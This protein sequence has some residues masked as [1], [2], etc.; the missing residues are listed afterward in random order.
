M[1]NIPISG[2]GIMNTVVKRSVVVSL[3]MAVLSQVAI[4]D[5]ND[6]PLNDYN[7]RPGVD[8]GWAQYYAKSL[9]GTRK[10]VL[11][12][13]DGPHVTYTPKVLDVLKKYGATATFFVLGRNINS[14]TIPIIQ[15]MI[16]EGH[17][18]AGHD[19][20]HNNNNNENYTVFKQDLKKSINRLEDVTDSLG[21]HQKEMFFRFPYGAYGTRKDYHHMN[22]MKEVSQEIY[23]EN[24]LNF[25][26][27]EIDTE[28]WVP[29]ITPT[30]IKDIIVANIDGGT[31]YIHKRVNG[32]WILVPRTITN[33]IGGGIVLMHDV[34]S[35]SAKATEEFLKAAK[36]K[37]ITVVPLSSVKNYSYDGKECIRQ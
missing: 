17:T 6:F 2:G 34:K 25:V 10:V 13:D 11:T 26:F 27:W 18:V 4:A 28:D 23:G 5:N 7:Y 20:N 36:E 14:R 35:H 33:P 8:R 1:I 24:C 16:D 32:K 9:Y 21:V 22:V 3:L 15:R 12:F 29:G 31:T 37:A 30:K 19:H